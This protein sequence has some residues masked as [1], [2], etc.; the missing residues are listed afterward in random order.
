MEDRKL[1]V[2]TE[3]ADEVIEALSAWVETLEEDEVGA[4]RRRVKNWYGEVENLAGG[5]VVVAEEHGYEF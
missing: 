2:T 3:N 5:F 4:D 1:V